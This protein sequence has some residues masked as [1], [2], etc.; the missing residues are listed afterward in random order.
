[1]VTVAVTA[2]SRPE[3]G[4]GSGHG[5][6]QSHDR[7]RGGRVTDAVA[8]HG[9][10][11]DSWPQLQWNGGEKG[12]LT[13]P[14]GGGVVSVAGHGKCGRS[15]SM[16]RHQVAGRAHIRR[17]HWQVAVMPWQ[18]LARS[19]WQVTLAG[20]DQ[21]SLHAKAAVPRSLNPASRTPH[22]VFQIL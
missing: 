7:V 8:G 11:C 15:W 10:V 5:H 2:R 20:R 9:H 12:P 16:S 21:S 13:L 22:E 6:G 1:M 14:V 3:S 17:S 19:H 4:S 18:P